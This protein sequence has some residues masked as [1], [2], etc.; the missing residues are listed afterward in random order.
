MPPEL[1]SPVDDRA[2]SFVEGPVSGESLAKL[3]V[4]AVVV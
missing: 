1:K 3:F 2:F 4:W